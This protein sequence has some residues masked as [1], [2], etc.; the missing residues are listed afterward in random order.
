MIEVGENMPWWTLV[1]LRGRRTPTSTLSPGEERGE[2]R[3]RMEARRRSQDYHWLRLATSTAAQDPCRP[4]K[5]RRESVVVQ[6]GWLGEALG[7]PFHPLVSTMERSR[8]F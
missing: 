7:N 1:S 8:R 6:R 4:S 5:V 2:G 3:R